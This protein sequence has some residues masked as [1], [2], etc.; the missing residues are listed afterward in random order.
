MDNDRK[1]AILEYTMPTNQ[2]GLLRFLDAAL[3]FKSFVPDY[4][5]IAAPLHEMTHKDFDWKEVNWKKDY[6]DSFEELKN[7][8]AASQVNYFP[9]YDLPW[10]QRV[11]ALEV[12]VGAILFQ[13]RTYKTGLTVYDP[14]GFASSKFT[15]TALKW[16]AFKKEAYAAYF[17]V[18]Y[19][20][21]Y[22]R[23]KPVVLEIDHRNLL[24]IEISEVPIVV[25]WRVSLQSFIIYVKHI[26]WS[27]NKVADWLSRMK[28]YFESDTACNHISDVHADITLLRACHCVK[29]LARVSYIEHDKSKEALGLDTSD[30][31]PV[32]GDASAPH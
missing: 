18:H 17:G 19:F 25:R 8:L 3:F 32:E 28:R 31:V 15:A 23:G 20:S 10:I 22:L 27:Q 13:E 26:P 6:K 4:S 21:Y 7:A 29:T 12:E 30:E 11:D 1:K 14:I 5:K 9:D 2:K 24:W 16:D